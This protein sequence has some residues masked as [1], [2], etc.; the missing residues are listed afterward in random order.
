MSLNTHARRVCTLKCPGFFLFG[1]MFDQDF[2]WFL[3]SRSWGLFVCPKYYYKDPL[4]VCVCSNTF[5]RTR[6]TVLRVFFFSFQGYRKSWR[7]EQHITASAEHDVHGSRHSCNAAA[8]T[9]AT[10]SR[11][12]RRA[13]GYCQRRQHGHIRVSAPVPESTVELFDA[14]F[15]A[16]QEPVRQNCGSR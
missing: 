3:F 11:E 1:R 6:L 15:P 8:K 13:G 2:R 16:R 10:G 14:K 7:T 5:G 4:C 12:S 9:T